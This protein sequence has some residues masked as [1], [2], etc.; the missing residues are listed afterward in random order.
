MN[1]GD[2]ADDVTRVLTEGLGCTTALLYS[3][4]W[5]IPLRPTRHVMSALANSRL[6]KGV[7]FASRPLCYIVDALTARIRAAQFQRVSLGILEEELTAET[8][9]ACFA[10]F[11]T[12]NDLIRPEYEH[13]V[14]EWF[15]EIL[16]QHSGLTLRKVV[17]RN[18]D[19]EALGWYLYLLKPGGIGRV[20]QLG[21]NQRTVGTVLDSLLHSAWRNGA[22]AVQGRLQP[23]FA[24]VFSSM[25]CLFRFGRPWT[26]VYSRDAELLH[27]VQNGKMLFTGLEG[28]SWMSF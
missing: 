14:F 18:R 15:L 16:S 5:T 25:Y 21:A 28:E 13:D 8:L 7:S 17:V 3:T 1:L 24:E 19:G 27:A 11:T 4:H 23:R 9:T 2:V 6:M 12:K 10:E 26:V 22:V 20:I